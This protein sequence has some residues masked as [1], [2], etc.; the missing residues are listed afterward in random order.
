M[1]NI[2]FLPEHYREVNAQ[3]RTH[4]WRV[5][6]VAMGLGCLLSGAGYDKFQRSLLK[7]QMVAA[8]KR[9]TASQLLGLR[10]SKLESEL[11]A[12]Q[13]EAELYVYLEH[14]WPRSRI[15]AAVVAP[16]PKDIYL[17]RLD[18][19]YRDAPRA[20][21]RRDAVRAKP[22]KASDE[23]KTLSPARDDLRQ[24]RKQYDGQDLV[25]TLSGLVEDETSLH[26]YLAQLESS[27]W[28]TSAEL[29]D[30]QRDQH[31]GREFSRFQVELIV[32]AG[33]GQPDGPQPHRD[34]IASVSNSMGRR[35][36]P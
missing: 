13:D 29:G 7:S 18:I 10:I 33:Y 28:F 14:P 17:D 27:D 25:V 19:A 21:S 1:H 26:N 34:G 22:A 8:Q 11:H 31:D 5:I 4:L 16:L 20:V 6:V 23:N 12:T 15:I 36:V 2:D 32:R 9:Y 35:A 24:L 3:R 30:V